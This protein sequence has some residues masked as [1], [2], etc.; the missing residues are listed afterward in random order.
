MDYENSSLIAEGGGR[1]TVL[2]FFC[3]L[4]IFVH[5]T[6]SR[7]G[8]SIHHACGSLSTLVASTSVSNIY[9]FTRIIVLCAV[10][11]GTVSAQFSWTTI[12]TPCGITG[13]AT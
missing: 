13:G 11:V 5:L 12:D 1:G 8:M 3:C 6:S 7:C 10:T 4:A 9:E 2:L